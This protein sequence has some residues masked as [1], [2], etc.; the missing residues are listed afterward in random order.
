MKVWDVVDRP[1]DKT[2]VKSKYVFKL[3]TNENGNIER[4]KARLVAMGN[5]QV[6]GI[7]FNETFSPVLRSELGLVAGTHQET[8]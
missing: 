6:A 3:K 5:T 2:I 8:L 1:S 4:Y 7:D